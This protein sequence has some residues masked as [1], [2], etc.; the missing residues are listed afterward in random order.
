MLRIKTLLVSFTLFT[1][2]FS[3]SFTPAKGQS[4]IEF[5]PLSG[6]YQVGRVSYDMVDESR[7]EI[8]TANEYDV[9]EFSIT[10]FYPAIPNE[11]S[12]R[13][14]YVEAALLPAIAENTGI[15]ESVWQ[16]FRPHAY[17]NA[18]IVDGE[19][20]V[21]LFSH[22]SGTPLQAY[23]GLMEDLASHGYV[24]VGISHT[25]DTPAVA[26]SDGRILTPAEA[27]GNPFANMDLP[28]IEEQDQVL[29]S[30]ALGDMLFVLD[31]LSVLNTDDSLLANHLDL[32]RIG[33]IGHSFGGTTALQSAYVDE[34]IL[35]VVN[36]DGNILGEVRDNGLNRPI[37]MMTQDFSIIEEGDFEIVDEIDGEETVT[38]TIDLAGV[39]EDYANARESVLN[40]AAPGYEIMLPG[41]SHDTYVTDALVLAEAIPDFAMPELVGTIEDFLGTRTTIHNI[42]IAFFNT[43]VAG[44]N[45]PQMDDLSF[46]GLEVIVYNE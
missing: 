30:V 25:Y 46:E 6:T 22:G 35:A 19:F 13:A 45:L 1:V 26:L 17:G 3:F 2:L 40:H 21:L 23:T 32:S 27:D 20:P 37:M 12:V 42:V 4:D 39:I 16:A 10:V 33:A 44:E 5:P 15:P 8:F 41:A 11:D 29:L 18:P 43:Y 9:R 34:R 14:P 31:Q 7:N 28:S 38:T 36:L 24:V